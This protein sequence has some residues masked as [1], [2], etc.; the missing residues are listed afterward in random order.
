MPLVVTNQHYR[1]TTGEFV[2]LCL[3]PEVPPASVHSATINVA[4]YYLPAMW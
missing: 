1:S 4:H 3:L 2:P